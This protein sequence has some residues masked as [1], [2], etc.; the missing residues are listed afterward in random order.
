M[1][2][3]LNLLGGKILRCSSIYLY[4]FS[5]F[6]IHSLYK[7]YNDSTTTLNWN[8]SELVGIDWSWKTFFVFNQMF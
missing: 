5:N 1:L 3:S 2:T 6:G 4:Y 8:I 7:Y